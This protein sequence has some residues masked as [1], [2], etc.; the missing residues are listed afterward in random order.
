MT[1]LTCPISGMP[2][3]LTARGTA[4]QLD[5]RRAPSGAQCR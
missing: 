2:V 3:A 5:E 4:A 1:D